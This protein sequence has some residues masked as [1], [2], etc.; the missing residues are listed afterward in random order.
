M[1]LI[2]VRGLPGSGKSTLARGML[3]DAWAR[4]YE[5]DQYF[6]QDGTYRF[7]SARLG[8]AHHWCLSS[9]R[10]WLEEE[11]TRSRRAVVSNTF[12]TIRELRPY[13]DMARE[14]GIVPS[15]IVCQNQFENVH[16][17]PEETLNRMRTRFQWDISTLFAELK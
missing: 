14:L 3:T 13:F 16:S 9:T 8:E 12:T 17:V 15:V 11:D 10:R 6:M 5:A 1:E 2:L 7:D 4:H